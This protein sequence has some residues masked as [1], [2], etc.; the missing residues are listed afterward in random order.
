MIKCGQRHTFDAVQRGI[1]S[2]RWDSTGSSGV[3]S[4]FSGCDHDYDD[5]NLFLAETLWS[6]LSRSTKECLSECEE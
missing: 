1:G 4:G 5:Q 2:L 6:H 3:L